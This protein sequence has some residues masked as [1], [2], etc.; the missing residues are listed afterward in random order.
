MT[1][2]PLTEADIRPL[3]GG[4][5]SG[6]SVVTTTAAGGTPH[7]MTCSSLASVA[8]HPPTL[9]ICLRT[10][11]PTTQAVL[12]SGQLALNLLHED[13]RD[14]SDLFASGAAD[15]FTRTEWR[16]PLGAGG[17]HLTAAAHA[18]ADCAVVGTEEVGDH[19]AVFVRVH[20]VTQHENAE[21]LLYARRRYA[22]W[23]DA[24]TGAKE[25]ASHVGS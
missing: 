6:V 17:P 9:V 1:E 10:A 5:P 12:G 13:A 4:F 21:P 20:R 11:G 14:T 7:G 23:S 25:G 24:T 16:L 3:M 19:T 18:I 8:L 22:R 2:P 15:R